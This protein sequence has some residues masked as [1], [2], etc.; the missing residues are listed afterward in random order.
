[1]RTGLNAHSPLHRASYDRK[2]IASGY[3][4]GSEMIDWWLHVDSLTAWPF[5]ARLAVFDPSIETIYSIK[6]VLRATM[7]RAPSAFR[8]HPVVFI[9]NRSL[10][11]FTRSAHQILRI[12]SKYSVI[13][14]NNVNSTAV[15]QV[16]WCQ[17]P[18]ASQKESR[19]SNSKVWTWKRLI[20]YRSC[21]K[22]ITSMRLTT[23]ALQW[24]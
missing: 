20:C 14:L 13:S 15:E 4:N 19:K 23:Q 24:H 9:S 3:R 2:C 16:W 10:H 6:L 17:P 22:I 7:H 12:I 18:D 11:H 1:M 21:E 8:F 5:S